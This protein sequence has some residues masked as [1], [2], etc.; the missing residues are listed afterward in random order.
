MRQIT[1]RRTLVMAI[2]IAG[3]GLTLPFVWAFALTEYSVR[4]NTYPFLDCSPPSLTRNTVEAVFH[5]IAADELGLQDPKAT[6]SM[7]YRLEDER[8]PSFIATIS[9]AGVS[10]EKRQYFVEGNGCG[11]EIRDPRYRTQVYVDLPER[12]VTWVT[13]SGRSVQVTP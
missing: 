13:R 8:W 2:L 12:V 7:F 4:T 1:I 5:Q 3:L 9:V 10:Y 6:V 11:I